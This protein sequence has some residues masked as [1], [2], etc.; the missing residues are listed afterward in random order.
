MQ[1]RIAIAA[2]T[3]AVLIGGGTATAV[4][5]TDD[6]GQDDHRNS[7][8]DDPSNHRSN[9]RSDDR[10]EDPG[11]ATTATGSARVRVGDAVAAAVKAVPGKVTEAELDDAGGTTVW[12]VDVYGSDRNRHDV[13]V[14]AG[15]GKVLG[16]HRS[17]DGRGA[18]RPASVSLAAAVDAALRSAPGT[19]TSIELEGADSGYG[20]VHWEVGVTGGDGR[21]HELDVDAR[22]ARVA[23]DRPGEDRHHGDDDRGHGHGHDD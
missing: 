19:V 18:P 23:A 11:A 22:S 8:S 12:K 13:T 9:D 5:L 16:S 20:A 10:R 1:R 2:V 21:R 4:A 3:A 6:H 7:R 17:D 15:S 14:D